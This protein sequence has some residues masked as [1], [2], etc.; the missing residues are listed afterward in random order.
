MSGPALTAGST[1]Q[2]PHGGQVQIV[3]SNARAKASGQ[4]LA[5]SS[6]IFSVVGCLFN[7]N[8]AP[9]PCLTVQWMVSDLQVRAGAATLSQGSVGL[10]MNGMQAPQGPVVV[11]VTQSAVQ[12]R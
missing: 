1:L 12:T 2:C 6:D 7:V 11:V 3:P 10:C 8:G 4:L 9:S 5:T